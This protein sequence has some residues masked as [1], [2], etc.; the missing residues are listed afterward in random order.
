MEINGNIINAGANLTDADLS[1][2]DLSGAILDDVNLTG[3][4]LTGTKTGPIYSGDGL[5]LPSGYNLIADTTSEFGAFYI[6]GPGVDLS[7]ADFSEHY[8]GFA[9]VQ[10]GGITGNPTLPFMYK[11]IDG[12]IFG[13]DVDLS[14]TDLTGVKTGPFD[15]LSGD[16][17]T[18]PVGY[19][20]IS[21][22]DYE[23]VYIVGP[24]VD[25]SGADFSEANL[26]DTDLTNVKINAATAFP[27]DLTEEQISALDLPDNTNFTLGSGLVANEG[28]HFDSSGNVIANADPAGSLL[29]SGTAAQDEV[30]SLDISG[31]SDADGLGAFSYAWYADDELIG[32]AEGD[33]LTLSQDEVG[34]VI[35]AQVSYTDGFGTD[36]VLISAT[37]DPVSDYSGPTLTGFGIASPIADADGNYAIEYTASTID[38]VITEANFLFHNI[39]DDIYYSFNDSNGD[40]IA[41]SDSFTASGENDIFSGTYDLLAVSLTS[42]NGIHSN[43]MNE[44]DIWI[45]DVD[46]NN[47]GHSSHEL[48]FGDLLLGTTNSDNSDFDGF[49]DLWGTSGDDV[50]YMLAGDDVVHGTMGNDTIIGGAGEDHVVYTHSGL[51]HVWINASDTFWQNLDAN[52]VTK[53]YEPNIG[54]GIYEFYLD[55]VNTNDDLEALNASEGNDTIIAG[56]NTT[57]MV[58]NAGNDFIDASRA[59]QGV[60]IVADDDDDEVIGSSYA[61]SIDGGSGSDILY[62][63]AGDDTYVYRF[64]G[65]DV[66]DDESGNDTLSIFSRLEDGARLFGEMYFDDADQLIIE[67]HHENAPD[68]IIAAT[69]IENLNFSA[70]DN[71]FDPFSTVIFNESIHDLNDMESFSFIGTNGENSI[72]TNTTDA[73]TD[74]HAGDGDDVINISGSG[75]AWT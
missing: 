45:E 16:N 20:A 46:G 17:L 4:K 8:D 7:G 38:G 42:N 57:L 52:T 5:T 67:G 37:T 23:E 75:F 40:G 12:V 64:D 48:T 65:A 63:G 58:G 34:K 56:A 13:H 41:V 47:I 32:G 2:G 43:Y 15:V 10:S 62:G 72:T 44:G 51:D 29:I 39:V 53:F 27:D 33:T 49:D 66:I 30:L 14:N 19:K 25:L 50:I 22:G 60:R 31:L 74:V 70:D 28:Y 73:Y 71:S 59:E 69:G 54:D 6:V 36:E 3:A 26:S 9:G 68:A 1:G 55:S 18:L 11:L 21:S 24:G 35:S 61:D